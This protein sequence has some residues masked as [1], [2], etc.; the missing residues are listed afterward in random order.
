MKNET[1]VVLVPSTEEKHTFYDVY[2]D[3]DTGNYHLDF[4]FPAH[5]VQAIKDNT[6]HDE[7]QV[8]DVVEYWNLMFSA[9]NNGIISILTHA[10]NTSDVRGDYAKNGISSAMRFALSL[11]D[12][13]DKSKVN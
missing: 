12:R 10:Y 3:R 2:M 7:A 8:Q 13:A 5:M 9:L 1:E 6:H 4:I 11:F